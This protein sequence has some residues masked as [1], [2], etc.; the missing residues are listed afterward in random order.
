M[1][2][3]RTH[4]ELRRALAFYAVV[5]ITA[6]LFNR[7]RVEMLIVFSLA[8]LGLP[9]I[10]G[11]LD[12]IIRTIALY[13]GGWKTAMGLTLVWL[14]VPFLGLL[15]VVKGYLGAIFLHPS[16]RDSLVYLAQK[17]LLIAPLAVAEEFFFRGYL[18]ETVFRRLWRESRIGPLSLKNL[19]TSML[20]GLAHGISYLT[21]TAFIT[22]F[23]GL[24]LGWLTE[25]AG[26]SIWPA[27]ALH[28]VGNL[29]IAWL[30]LLISMNVKWEALF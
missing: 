21:P 27:T 14:L 13:P 5:V 7:L 2:T 6:L 17:G 15:A 26:G 19:A 16:S 22:F 8:C 23:S 3:E 18:Q 25:R 1:R 9:F 24:L 30:G 20:F 29:N 11:R 10:G 4:S 28:A 12:E